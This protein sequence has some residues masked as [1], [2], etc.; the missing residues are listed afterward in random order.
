VERVV[1]NEDR[2]KGCELC[3]SVCPQKIVFMADRI[4]K[5]GYRPAT[6]VDQD[7]CTSCTFCA[8]ICPDLVI[9]VFRPAKEAKVS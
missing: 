3:I 2:C 7:K 9:E 4:N 5:L 8:K 1:F 6:V